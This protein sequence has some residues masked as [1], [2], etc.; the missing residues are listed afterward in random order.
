M[1]TWVLIDD[2]KEHSAAG[3]QFAATLQSNWEYPLDLMF[4][5]PEGEFVSKLNSFRDL[6]AHPHVGHPRHPFGP[7]TPTKLAVFH[8]H[9]MRFLK[10]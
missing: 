4:L 7:G 10:R 6:P 9:A 3:N 8:A 2:L 5:S 1:A